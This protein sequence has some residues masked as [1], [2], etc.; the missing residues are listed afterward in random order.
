MRV[1][2]PNLYPDGGRYFLDEDGVK[3][4]AENWNVLERKIANYRKKAGKP[5]GNPMQEIMD[6]VCARLPSYCV[7]E[8]AAAAPQQSA[9]IVQRE[10]AG[11]LTKRVLRWLALVVSQFRAGTITKVDRGEARRRAEICASCP[12][13][14]AMS[15]ACGACKRTRKGVTDAVLRNERRVNEGLKACLALGEDT[16]LSVHLS[17]PPTGKSGLPTHCWR[18]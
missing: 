4:R 14:R 9:P 13:Q 16:S 18:R 7:E 15:E 8:S 2:N 1:M 10:N 12:L 17:L 11:N 5:P 3:F 6:Q